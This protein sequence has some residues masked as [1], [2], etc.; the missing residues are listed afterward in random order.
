MNRLEAAKS[1][2]NSFIIFPISDD[3][4]LFVMDIGENKEYLLAEGFEKGIYAHSSRVAKRLSDLPFDPLFW[5]KV[6]TK[7][8]LNLIRDNYFTRKIIQ[9]NFMFPSGARCID[10]FHHRHFK[11]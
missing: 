1:L 4:K 9:C 3:V 10:T 2:R 5:A 7:D 11:L 6:S 8:L